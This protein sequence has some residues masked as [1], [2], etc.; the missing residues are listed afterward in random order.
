MAGKV[1]QNLRTSPLAASLSE[2]E[3][4]SLSSCARLITYP[5]GETIL[6]TSGLDER[7]F[8]LR[9]GRLS[10]SLS[11][12]TETG[13]CGGEALSELAKPGAPFGWATWI[14]T[15]RLSISAIAL[16]PV[17]LVAFDLKRLGDTQTFLKV[18][19]RMLQI[20]YAHLQRSGICPPNVGAFLKMKQIFNV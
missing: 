8:L 13:Q 5:E 1:I 12:W 9:K 2:A 16:E 15:D 20:L 10:L 6:D 17:S 14:R 11:M 4:R 3:I 7:V 18:S 19:Q